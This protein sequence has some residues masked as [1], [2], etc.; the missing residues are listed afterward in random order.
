MNIVLNYQSL[1]YMHMNVY[2]NKYLVY[3][4]RLYSSRFPAD[5]YGRRK[6]LKMRT[7]WKDDKSVDNI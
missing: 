7:P 3:D 1:F 2:A 6:T 4:A 5:K